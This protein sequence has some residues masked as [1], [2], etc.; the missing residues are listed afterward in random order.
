MANQGFFNI[1]P[2]AAQ[3]QPQQQPP[4]PKPP[5]PPQQGLVDPRPPGMPPNAQSA[6][7]PSL[8]QGPATPAGSNRLGLWG[9]PPPGGAGMGQQMAMNASQAL[10]PPPPNPQQGLVDPRP[11]S[12][13]P[14]QFQQQPYPGRHQGHDA[15]APPRWFERN[16]QAPPM[17]DF[18]SAQPA[19]M[20]GA[21]A[22]FPGQ[23]PPPPLNDE[24]TSDLQAR[25]PQ[26][27]RMPMRRY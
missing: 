6:P 14:P 5:A 12:M 1:G 3:P 18:A 22:S 4:K 10:P 23:P 2:Q 17:Q 26:R 8:P 21:P 9:M 15:G 16:Q 25:A 7:A 13:P 11:G 20:V 27:Q 19:G 24:L